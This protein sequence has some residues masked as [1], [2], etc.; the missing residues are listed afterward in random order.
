MLVKTDVVERGQDGLF[1]SFCELKVSSGFGTAAVLLTVW[2]HTGTCTCIND[3]ELGSNSN[4]HV[5][6]DRYEVLAG[7]I[8]SPS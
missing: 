3:G 1:W 4:I 8:S 6:G 5:P 7:I 2:A